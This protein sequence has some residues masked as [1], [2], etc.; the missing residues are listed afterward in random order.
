MASLTSISLTSK[1][2]R[3]ARKQLES[4]EIH[5]PELAR[6]LCKI[7]PARCPFEQEVK[8]F[9]HTVFHIP[10]LCKLNPLYEQV[11]DLRFRCLSYLADECGEDITLYC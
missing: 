7:I 1:L 5:D 2:L 3:S 10:S 6:L 4:L 11:V 8:L 9:N